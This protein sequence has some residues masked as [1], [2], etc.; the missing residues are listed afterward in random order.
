MKRSKFSFSPFSQKVL[1]VFVLQLSILLDW[2]LPKEDERFVSQQKEQRLP[3]TKIAC[4][5][6]V[7]EKPDPLRNGLVIHYS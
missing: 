7:L 3:E 2:H 1:G 5:L 4:L 6:Q